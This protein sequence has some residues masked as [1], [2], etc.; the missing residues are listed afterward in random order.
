MF[1]LAMLAGGRLSS[2][3]VYHT[4]KIWNLADGACV[5]MLEGHGDA[6]ICLAVLA[7]GRLASGSADQ[8]IKVWDLALSRKPPTP[9]GL[10]AEYDHCP[11]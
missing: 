4:I 9:N 10:V 1:C 2:G 7:G 3:S 8:T 5:E 6:V 11:G